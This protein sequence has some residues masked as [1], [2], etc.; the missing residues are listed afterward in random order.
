LVVFFIEEA[1]DA[2]EDLIFTLGS[3]RGEVFVATD[4]VRIFE[5]HNA[6]FGSF[7]S[8]WTQ[9]SYQRGVLDAVLHNRLLRTQLLDVSWEGWRWQFKSLSTIT[10]TEAAAVEGETWM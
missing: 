1:A 3:G 4:G 9:L 6:L 7:A 5:V 10:K 8:L 2:A